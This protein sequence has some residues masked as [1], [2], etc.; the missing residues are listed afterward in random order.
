MVVVGASQARA[1]AD[2]LRTD[3]HLFRR[4]QVADPRIIELREWSRLAEEL[5]QERV[6]LG[7]RL[8]HQLWRYYPQMLELT[9]D[10]ASDWFLKLWTL[11]PTPDKGKHLRKMAIERLLKQYRIRRIDTETVQRSLHKPAIP[12]AEGVPEAASAHIR[13]LIGRL[14]LVNREQRDAERK[15]DVLCAAL[16]SSEQHDV[17][18]LRSLPGIGR[19]NLATLLAEAS[20]PLSRRDYPALRTLS[21]VAPV[22]KR[23]G[24]TCIVVMRFAAHARLRNTVYHWARVAIQHDPKSRRRY[25]ALRQRGHSHGRAIRG[26]ADQLL[27]VAC[28]LLQRQTPFDP[29]HGQ[30]AAA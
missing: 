8:H 27:N 6:R 26:V 24:K 10:I 23:S 4:L 20:G 29:A 19:I 13:S 25:T 17:A 18:I 15:L 2:G 1:A 14:H 22:T 28:V 3:R 30:P 16:E 21:G 7:N 12:V 5:Q 11:A 9:D